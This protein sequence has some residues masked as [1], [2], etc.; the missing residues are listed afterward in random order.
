MGPA[1]VKVDRP[2]VT[3]RYR[4]ADSFTSRVSRQKLCQIR[5][6]ALERQVLNTA[7]WR[8][9]FGIW[10]GGK[11]GRAFYRSL[12]ESAKAH[13]T[14]FYDIDP[15]KIGFY[16][17]HGPYCKTPGGSKKIIRK[18][19]VLHLDELTPP[20]ITC[21]SLDRTDGEFEKRLAATGF[22]EGTDWYPFS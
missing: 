10:G 21:V 11:N 5:A 3:Y 14:A 20:F 18:I 7:R 4:G 8:S 12:S 22:V 2:L 16:N 6:Q 13:V 9:G 17:D 15:A 19:P 1:I